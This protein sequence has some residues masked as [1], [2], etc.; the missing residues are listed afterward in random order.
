MDKMSR[1]GTV[2][3]ITKRILKLYETTPKVETVSF[4]YILYA[5]GL[6]TTDLTSISYVMLEEA[7]QDAQKI[8]QN[9]KEVGVE[10]TFTLY[11]SDEGSIQVI[12]A[13]LE[14][15]TDEERR[16]ALNKALTKFTMYIEKTSKS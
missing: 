5:F 15:C 4:P 8:I 2:K 11:A 12:E 7:L 10:P 3:E 14:M 1:D 9:K 13:L 16:A 6:Q